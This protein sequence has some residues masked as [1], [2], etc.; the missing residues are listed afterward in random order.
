M[1]EHVQARTATALIDFDGEMLEI[2]STDGSKRM[3]ASELTY[4]A[5]EPDKKGR[6]SVTFQAL[7]GTL[8]MFVLESQ[9]VPD[10]DRLLAALAA[11]GVQRAE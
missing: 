8:A 1:A 9:F 7:G 10:F 2:F 5:T 11:S 3:P 6:V 4:R